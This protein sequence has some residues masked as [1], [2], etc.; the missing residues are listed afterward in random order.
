MLLDY[1][2]DI[3]LKNNKKVSPLFYATPKMQKLI[4]IK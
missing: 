3:S 4:G 1:G 2:G